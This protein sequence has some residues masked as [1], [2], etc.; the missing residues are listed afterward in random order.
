[1][2]V[3]SAQFHQG[4]STPFK[5]LD[6]VASQ[7]IEYLMSMPARAVLASGFERWLAQSRAWL[8]RDF[9]HLSA[10]YQNRPPA[11]DQADPA[12]GFCHSD[13]P[14]DAV[15]RRSR[16]FQEFQ[17][18]ISHLS[19]VNPIVLFLDDLQWSDPDSLLLLRS[20]LHHPSPPAML[21][22]LGYR[23]E[24][25]GNQH[26]AALRGPFPA[27][28]F[29][30]VALGPMAGEDLHELARAL[31]PNDAG[32]AEHL[33]LES[34]GNPFLFRQL[35]LHGAAAGAPLELS[36]VIGGRLGGLPWYA[37]EFLRV[38]AVARAPVQLPVLR[39]AA[40]I[41]D[42]LLDAKVRLMA[43]FL[44]R[45]ASGGCEV[46]HDRIAEAVA[47]GIEPGHRRDLHERLATTL[48]AF[49]HPDPEAIA[50]HYFSAGRL[51]DACRTAE[52]AALRATEVLAFE[53]AAELYERLI[54]WT[55]DT[56]RIADL[57]ERR[58]EALVNAGRGV[59]GARCFQRAI[60]GGATATSRV[61]GSGTRRN[62]CA[63]A[64]SRKECRGCG[65]SFA[66][67]VFPFPGRE[68]RP[69]AG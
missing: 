31:S 2:R 61:Y 16:L 30:H 34:G 13:G 25:P 53:K 48:E 21:L 56:A 20:V 1:M 66:I 46:Y 42:G 9:F 58:G 65:C 28:L 18:L 44:I 36:G 47:A 60:E 62:C 4:E 22:V 32:A 49:A 5:A 17:D 64:R 51:A 57:E 33:A 3:F 12:V 69:S 40:G 37:R 55:E 29:E 26:L 68:G 43:A 67:T 15:S 39:D 63:R 54:G 52:I 24:S 27:A 6:E 41:A 59:D 7:A 45:E 50:A 38:L 35:T 19:R 11:P 10:S 8:T 14:A 23:E